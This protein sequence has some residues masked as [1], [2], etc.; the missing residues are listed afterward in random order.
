MAP[1]SFC[2]E[3]GRWRSRASEEAHSCS[4]STSYLASE[5]LRMVAKMIKSR[6]ELWDKVAETQEASGASIG[7][8]VFHA[9]SPTSG[10]E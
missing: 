9:E 4:S 2:G 8:S 5:K 3:S 6:A 1:V 10:R 7:A